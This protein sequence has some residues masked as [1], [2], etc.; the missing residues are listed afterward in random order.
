MIIITK[1][2]LSKFTNLSLKQFFSSFS[3]LVNLKRASHVLFCLYGSHEDYLLK[4]AANCF[5]R[6]LSQRELIKYI[7]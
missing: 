4:T 7:K 3:E 6:M 2:I 1:F 5:S